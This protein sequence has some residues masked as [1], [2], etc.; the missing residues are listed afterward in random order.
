VLLEKIIKMTTPTFFWVF[1]R[2]VLS[3]L[4]TIDKIL[5]II[6]I[7]SVASLDALFI[8]AVSQKRILETWNT[9]MSQFLVAAII[10]YYAVKLSAIGI[11]NKL[12]IL[13]GHAATVHSFSKL[14][15]CNYSIVNRVSISAATST[16]TLIARNAVH[17][18]ILQSSNALQ[19]ALTFIMTAIAVIFI[20]P[21]LVLIF[22]LVSAIPISVLAIL[23]KKKAY[24]NSSEITILFEKESLLITNFWKNFKYNF[25]EKRQDILI[26]SFSNIDKRLRLLESQN[27]NL[28][29]YQRQLLEC[30]AVLTLVLSYFIVTSTV[31]PGIA[32]TTLIAVAYGVYRTLPSLQLLLGSSSLISSHLGEL[33][34]LVQHDLKV[35]DQEQYLSV[36]SNF[37]EYQPKQ[38]TKL[39][40]KPNNCSLIIKDLT[41]PFSLKKIPDLSIKNY[42]LVALSGVSGSGKSTL[43][44]IL[45]GLYPPYS[46]EIKLFGK[47]IIDLRDEIAYL[48]QS[49]APPNETIF[50]FLNL[51]DTSKD[52]TTQ[53]LCELNLY[54]LLKNQPQGFHSLIGQSE[55]FLSGGQLSRLML[56]K[57]ISNYK[58]NKKF[59]LLDEFTSGN[60][61][62]MRV[63]MLKVLKNQLC[64]NQNLV[65]FTSHHNDDLSHADHLVSI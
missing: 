9:N 21:Y 1:N 47:S 29:N 64:M 24:T 18:C 60:D 22:F 13:A 30:V 2:Y 23:T 52:L 25:A 43:M 57:F 26:K 45:A 4:K 65:I 5:L 61:Q 49:S 42:N 55:E 40:P 20:A 36:F 14:L 35:N 15:N 41:L 38:E 12:T 27:L 63:T 19:G 58:S 51:N 62:S 44:D 50:E 32:T 48:P 37:T 6:A 59:F 17:G 34:A 3:N 16:Y 54:D 28:S 53:L 56:A 31:N 33:K 39:S 7:L 10:I 8:V 11:V 46:G